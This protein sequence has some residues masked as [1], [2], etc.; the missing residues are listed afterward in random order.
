MNELQQAVEFDLQNME[1]C[2]VQFLIKFRN[3]KHAC[4]PVHEIHEIPFMKNTEPAI[5]KKAMPFL[6]RSKY[7]VQ[8]RRSSCSTPLFFFS[9]LPSEN[10]SSM[11]VR[12]QRASLSTAIISHIPGHFKYKRN[13]AFIIC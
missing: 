1:R 7:Y 4:M 5:N 12:E 13:E 3:F 6:T 11:K 9:L 2:W 10:T 8:E